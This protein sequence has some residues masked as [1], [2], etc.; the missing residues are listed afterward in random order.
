[1]APAALIR[2]HT[3]PN[4]NGPKHNDTVTTATVVW[5][6]AAAVFAVANWWSRWSHHRPTELWSK[7]LTLVALIGAALALDPIDPVVRA[8]FVVALVLSLA[9]DVFLLGDDSWFVPGLA[10]FL[11]GH[12]AYVVGFVLAEP[13]R[14]WSFALAWV[15]LGVLAATIGRRIVAG[16]VERRP[17]LRVPVASYLG[18]ISLMVASAAAAGNWWAVAGAVLFLTSDTIL[19]WRQFVSQRPWMPVAIMVTYHLAQA[20]LVIS[21]I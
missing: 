5:L 8:W 20:G 7:P 18:V 1:V 9:G 13:W 12:L 10:A 11:A 16:A 6:V 3:V 14:W 2:E 15:G 19:G 17:A 4:H 21:L